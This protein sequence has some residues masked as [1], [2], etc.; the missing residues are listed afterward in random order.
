MT[1][2]IP[3]LTLNM[4]GRTEMAI[5]KEQLHEQLLKA[6][7]L[8]HS[9]QRQLE[10][11]QEDLVRMRRLSD[12]LYPISNQARQY[13]EGMKLGAAAGS[14]FS[15]AGLSPAETMPTFEGQLMQLINRFNLEGESN[16]PELILARFLIMCLTAWN[17]NTIEREDWYANHAT[18]EGD[19]P[20]S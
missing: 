12:T 7:Q 5:T 9:M 2:W 6:E 15:P 20:K 11:A 13:S 10:C 1:C 16:T 4:M 14:L 17:V 18:I 19:L 3:N 8:M